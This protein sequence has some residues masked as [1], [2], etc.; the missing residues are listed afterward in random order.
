MAAPAVIETDRPFG[1]ALRELL[2]ENDYSTETGRPNWSAF[3]SELEGVHYETLRRAVV[4]QRRP[5]PHLIE[6]CARVLRIRSEYF[7]E[8]RAYLAQREFDPEHVGVEQAARNLEAWS[9]ARAHSPTNMVG[10][11]SQIGR[12]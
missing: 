3:A 2:V 8:Y 9:Q 6:E 1:A 11:T 7:L 10:K 12:N 4:G 5:S